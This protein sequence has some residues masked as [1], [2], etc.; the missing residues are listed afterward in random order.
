MRH[1]I[2]LGPTLSVEEAQ[3]ILPGD[4]YPPARYADVV[5][6]VDRDPQLSSIV[7]IDGWQ[8]NSQT[9]LHK[10][11]LYALER[12]IR[13]YGAS[14]VGAIRA[15][16]TA[17]FGTIGYGEIYDM[18]R[19]GICQDDDEV[20]SIHMAT[21]EG[22]ARLTEPMV[23]VRATAKRA[24]EERVLA[25]ADAD[26]V[27]KNAKHLFYKERTW[28][29]ILARSVEAGLASAACDAFNAW[30][31]TGYVDVK[32]RDAIGL[33]RFVA[34]HRPS[35]SSRVRTARS[36]YFQAL[37]EREKLVRRNGTQISLDSIRNYAAL[38][39]H[40]FHNL[41]FAALNQ[42]LVAIFA[43]FLELELSPAELQQE[44][45]RFLHRRNL[46]NHAEFLE[47]CRE[48]DLTEEEANELILSAAK[49]RRMHRWLQTARM[50]RRTT[51]PI[52]NFMRWIGIYRKW[53]DRAAQWESIPSNGSL[54]TFDGEEI[55]ALWDE[56]SR[57]T[58]VYNEI[59]LEEWAADRGFP[60]IFEFAL[61]LARAKARRCHP[62]GSPI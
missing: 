15:A 4:Y 49:C 56:H 34:E 44:R 41:S 12:G 9:V 19:L 60:E 38:H 61:E 18:F 7:L 62:S 47:W 8:G 3:R 30:V 55:E 5:S 53:A 10:E 1:A 33:L 48:N 14:D 50:M 26:L 58:G 13:V 29:K 42:E 28:E 32:R 25:P 16:E 54:Q 45:Q 40:G 35:E 24:V 43:D 27:E 21:A 57:T 2:F 17:A 11:I 37:L 59:P 36:H 46:S 39:L 51:R 31:T 20:L 23:N 6:L 22:Y 52:L